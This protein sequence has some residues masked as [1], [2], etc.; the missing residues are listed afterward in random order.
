VT[1][2]WFAD[3]VLSVGAIDE[4][5]GVA[6]FSVHGP[7]VG[8][9]APGTKIVSL[10]PA[11]GSGSLANLTFEDGNKASEIQG[12]SFASPY[13]AGLAALVKAMYPKLT[14]KG[15]V[16]RIKETAQHPAAPGG[17]DNFV[18]YGVIDPVA[19]LTQVLPSEV[20]NQAPIPAPQMA[21]LPPAN[22]HSSTPMIVALAGTAGG[23]LALLIT[24]FV[25][26]TIR[27]NRPAET[28]T[29]R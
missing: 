25:M 13:V 12:T 14:A 26:H 9:A 19:A 11:E 10:D 20:G 2:P 21:Q 1:P 22:D 3:D 18:G 8:V 28:G 7:W 29:R 4:S 27:R 15:I 5:G 16:N 24:L 17:R 23:V 6:P